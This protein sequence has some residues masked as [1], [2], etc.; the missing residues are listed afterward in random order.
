[1]HGNKTHRLSPIKL[2]GELLK[3]PD[4]KPLLQIVAELCYLGVKYRTI[5]AYYFSRYLFKRDK[6]NIADYFPGKFL[7]G[8]KAKFNKKEACEIVDNKLSFDFYFR[9]FNLCMPQVWMSNHKNEFVVNH[10]N[11]D[12][13]S[14]DEFSKVL[15]EVMTSESKDNTIFIKKTSDSY[16]GEHIY[17]IHKDE[18]KSSREKVE[19]IFTEVV[20]SGYIFQE[21][22]KQHPELDRLNPHCLN[23]L[24]LD[25]FVNSDKSVEIISGYLK[26]NLKNHYIDNEPTGGCEVPFELNTGTLNKYGHL[27]L[28]YN[29]LKRPTQHPITQTVFEHFEVPFFNE[30]KELVMKAAGLIPGLRLV[31]WDVAIG[32]SG[33]ILI[34]GNSDYDIAANDLAYGGYRSNPVFQKVLK[35]I[36]YW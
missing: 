4:R 32:E 26:T 1:M 9:Q 10:K 15:H 29:G 11:L 36:G 19:F 3:D 24:R 16:G 18:L 23:T 20:K 21:T 33:P 6:R 17:K 30:A 28:K 22:V 14:I 25:T 31:G 2:L 35:E 12:I 5:P 27:T 7:Y 8:I 34:E 13:K